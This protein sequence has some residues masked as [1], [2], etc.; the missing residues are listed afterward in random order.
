[1]P[2]PSEQ[3][4]VSLHRPWRRRLVVFLWLVVVAIS[5]AAGIFVGGRFFDQTVVDSRR[6]AS[7]L[8]SMRDYEKVLRQQLTNAELASQVDRA[9]LENVRKLVTSLQLQLATNEEELRLYR[10]LLLDADNESGLQIGELMLKDSPE[11]GGTAYRLIIQQKASNQ[12]SVKINIKVELEGYRKGIKETLGLDQ[13]DEQVE[14]SP[15]AVKLKYFHM[16][17][18]T[19]NLPEGFEPRALRVSVWKASAGAHPVER[20][21]DWHVD[22]A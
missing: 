5:F 14:S 3:L 22:E 20:R 18:G 15:I 6:M 19:L 1:M 2:G 10:N 17:E 8:E 13:L 9:S 16:L 21:F 12:K 7:D 4:I 11:R